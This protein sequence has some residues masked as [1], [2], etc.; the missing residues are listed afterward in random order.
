MIEILVKNNLINLLESKTFNEFL[1][2]WII[3]QRWSGLTGQTIESMKI[4]DY[5]IESEYENKILLLLI[6]IETQFLNK[7]RKLL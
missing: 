1:L 3:K 6:N 2:D 7:S 5:F 4:I